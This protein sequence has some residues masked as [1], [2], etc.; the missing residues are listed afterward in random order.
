M[1]EGLMF[2]LDLSPSRARRPEWMDDG[3]RIEHPEVQFVPPQPDQRAACR[4]RPGHLCGCLCRAECL[5][6]AL[7][8]NTLLGIWAGTTTAERRKLR[9]QQAA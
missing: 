9:R 5:D 8:D 2:G 3:A 7:A 4:R 1:L 6:Y